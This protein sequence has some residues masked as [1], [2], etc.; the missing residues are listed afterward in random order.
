MLAFQRRFD[1]HLAALERRIRGGAIG[2]IEIITITS[3]DPAP[4]PVSYV[5][6]SGGLYRDSMIHDFDEARFLLGEEPT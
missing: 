4:P 5:K 3:R 6:R 1:P 2:Q